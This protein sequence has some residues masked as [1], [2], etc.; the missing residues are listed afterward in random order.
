MA[1]RDGLLASS[2]MK[3]AKFQDSFVKERSLAEVKLYFA[4]LFYA[5]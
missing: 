1:D 2:H 5:V 4:V 3:V